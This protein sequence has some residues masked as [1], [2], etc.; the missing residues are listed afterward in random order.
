MPVKNENLYV[1]LVKADILTFSVLP[2]YVL[3]SQAVPVPSPLTLIGALMYPIKRFED[4]AIS[5][6]MTIQDLVKE[7]YERW[8]VRYASFWVPPYTETT[9]LERDL[10]LTYQRP[11]RAKWLTEE[12]IIKCLNYISKRN[13]GVE[14]EDIDIACKNLYDETLQN[15]WGVSS[16]SITFFAKSSYLLYITSNKDIG[17]YAWLITRVGRKEDVA[18]V[19]DVGVYEL[20]KM[21]INTYDKCETHFYIPTRLMKERPVNAASWILNNVINGN[22]KKEEFIIPIPIYGDKIQYHPDLDNAV[23]INLPININRSNECVTIP[24]EVIL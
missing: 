18:I 12:N 3:S 19:Y 24:K 22:L 4:N 1:V 9:T 5:E 8:G 16:R 14:V 7:A 6:G 13:S 21:I 23:I 15:M 2:P 11:Q 17:K 10:G 20:Q